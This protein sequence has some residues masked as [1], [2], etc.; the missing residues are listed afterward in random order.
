MGVGAHEGL[1]QGSQTTASARQARDAQPECG[2]RTMAILTG[3]PTTPPA[4]SPKPAKRLLAQHTRANTRANARRSWDFY[5]PIGWPVMAPIVDGPG[6]V[7]VYFECLERCQMGL[8]EKVRI[9]ILGLPRAI[10]SMGHPGSVH[11]K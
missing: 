4:T 10:L 3:R 11:P 2:N 9:S 5:K 1:T 8:M 7:D 6:S